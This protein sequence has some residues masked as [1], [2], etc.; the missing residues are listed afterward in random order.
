MSPK[1]FKNCPIWSLF[2][3]GHR[4]WS[5]YYLYYLIGKTYGRYISWYSIITLWFVCLSWSRFLPHPDCDYVNFC[6]DNIKAIYNITAI[7]KRFHVPLHFCLQTHFLCVIPLDFFIQ[8]VCE[9]LSLKV[10]PFNT[11]N[12]SLVMNSAAYL[13]GNMLLSECLVKR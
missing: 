10:G 9:V 3:L 6:S 7:W 2:F 11:P 13:S 4:K 12:L 8:S 5:F 1:I